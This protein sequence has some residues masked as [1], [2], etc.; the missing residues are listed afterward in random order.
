MKFFTIVISKE[1]TA[2]K[3]HV[4]GRQCLTSFYY[5]SHQQKIEKDWKLLDK[6]AKL[7]RHSFMTHFR[8]ASFSNCEIPTLFFPI[9]LL[10]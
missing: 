7:E 4:G 2:L 6:K 5:L 1:K 10:E 9:Q 3:R 8:K